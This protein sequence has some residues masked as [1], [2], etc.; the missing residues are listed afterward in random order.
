MFR[1]SE[2]F[3]RTVV[4]QH[5]STLRYVRKVIEIEEANLRRR[6]RE[7]GPEHILW[8]RR[9]AYRVLRREDLTVTRHGCTVSGGG[10]A[11]SAHYE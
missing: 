9:V 11:P 1:V 3:A 2:P 10:R 7:I 6:L 8:G 5:R 4:C